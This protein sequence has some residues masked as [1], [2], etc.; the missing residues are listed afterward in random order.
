MVFAH[1]APYPE[2]VANFCCHCSPF[3][4][5]LAGSVN[6]VDRK[7]AWPHGR[8]NNRGKGFKAF[9]TDAPPPSIVNS[10]VPERD[11]EFSTPAYYS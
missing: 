9:I 5:S 8:L 10:S 3:Q 2:V 1:G 6:V 11:R 4:F 7:V